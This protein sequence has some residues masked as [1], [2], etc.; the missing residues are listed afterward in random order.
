MTVNTDVNRLAGALAQVLI[1]AMDTD[2]K[3]SGGWDGFLNNGPQKY[4]VGSK[5]LLGADAAVHA[6][7]PNGIFSTA[8]IENLV[9]NAH[10]T[11]E[12][13]DQHLK[14]FGTIY[15]NPIFPSLTGFSEDTGAEPDGKCEDCLGGTMQG[16]NLTA[17]FGHI[18]RGSDEIH[19]MRTIQM[20]NRGETTPLT[21]LGDVLGPGGITKMPN[22]PT[23]W[24]EVTTK[25]EMVK[26]AILIQRKLMK[27]TWNGN[28]ANNTVGG[29][30]M[31][32]PGLETLVGT[33]KVDING[34]AC[35]SLDS[36][37]M[38][39][40]KMDV[41]DADGGGNDIVTYI[42]QMEWYIRHNAGRMGLMPVQWVI[43]MR[44]ELWYEL[45]AVWACRYLTNRCTQM[46]LGSEA[47]SISV[48]DDTAIKMRDAMRQGMYLIINGRQ[49]PVIACDGMTETT[50]TQDEELNPGQFMSDIFFLP[51]T[52]RGGM[53]VLYWEYLDYSKADAQIAL[54]K[55]G[56]DFWTDGGRFMWT[57]ERMRGCFKMNAEIDLRIILRTPHVAARLDNIK[58]T[59]L[60]HLR[61]PFFGDPYFKKGGVSTRTNPM[62][63]WYTEWSRPEQN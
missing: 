25:A 37:V 24:L 39:F 60:L 2:S 30:Y 63:N 17:T 6:H 34:A 27:M 44:P 56:N 38:D 18:C 55:S 19:I 13:L 50:P 33:G 10:M 4:M 41:G 32:F 14:A 7:G 21:L 46:N 26:V 16:C 54:T 58:Y 36:L 8:G 53:S 57:V 45:S 22:T 3:E 12:D 51:L 52:V 1:N 48:N 29:G 23:E 61:S 62:D 9:V 31:E 28:P 43:C 47:L 5:T 11:P 49:Y 59:P 15:M 20:I 42:S 35:E 40:A